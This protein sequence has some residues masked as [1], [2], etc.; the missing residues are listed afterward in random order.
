MFSKIVVLLLVFGNVPFLSMCILRVF[1]RIWN[2]NKTLRCSYSSCF[3]S[4]K[5]LW[6]YCSSTTFWKLLMH[7]VC[8][9]P[10]YFQTFC[11]VKKKDFLPIS[12]CFRL[13]SIEILFKKVQN[14]SGLV[15]YP[16]SVL[17][18]LPLLRRSVQFLRSVQKF[19]CCGSQIQNFLKYSDLDLQNVILVRIRI[20]A[21]IRPFY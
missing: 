20:Q 21:Q 11:L 15:F 9:K 7:T 8:K 17:G 10:V 3:L 14:W 19:H 5:F 13:N 1:E 6:S 18:L 16:S 2:Q 4:G 12:I